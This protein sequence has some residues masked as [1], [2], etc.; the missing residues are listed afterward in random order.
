MRNILITLVLLLSGCQT[1]NQSHNSGPTQNKHAAKNTR[2]VNKAIYN[3]YKNKRERYTQLQ[4]GAPKKGQVNFKEPVPR[5]EPLSRYGNPTEYHVNGKNYKVMTNPNRYKARGMA[6][7]YG[8]KFHKQRTSSGEPYDMY[9]MTAAHKTLPLPT[10]VRVK[11]LNNGKVAIVKVNDRGPFHTGRIIDLSYAAA[12]K[13]GVFPKGTAPVEVE[14]LMGPARQ[15]Y[16]YVQV[17]AFS[18]TVVAKQL[19]AK[20]GRISQSPVTI[21]YYKKHYI[22]R[23][24][25]FASKKG[26]D[27]L[28]QKLTRNGVKGTFSVLI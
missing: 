4:D 7:W 12:L 15:A 9:S 1:I 22:V 19:K 16:Y 17:G 25:P 28:K 6:S 14:A 23:I 3:R 13:L 20:L 2:H 11:N 10:Y 26:A 8:T 21:E 18:T 5:K 24:G 27:S